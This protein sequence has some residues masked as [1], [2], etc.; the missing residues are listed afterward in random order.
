MFRPTREGSGK[1]DPFLAWKVRL[2]IIGASLALAGM[3]WTIPWLMW[4]GVTVLAAGLG[5]RFLPRRD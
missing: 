1:D 3:G 2:F 4:A 5:L